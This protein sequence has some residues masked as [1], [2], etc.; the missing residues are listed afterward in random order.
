L[1]LSKFEICEGHLRLKPI[2]LMAIVEVVCSYFYHGLMAIT[3][4]IVG[5]A[6]LEVESD[7]SVFAVPIFLLFVFS[8]WK[9]VL[10]LKKMRIYKRL[11]KNE[12]LNGNK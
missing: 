4:L 10:E 11:L 3:S 2:D 5:F 12:Y 6:L 9:I 1:I 7:V 8:V